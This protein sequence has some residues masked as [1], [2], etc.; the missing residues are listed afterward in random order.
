M[1]LRPPSICVPPASPD[2]G[3]T[4]GPG[5]CSRHQFWFPGSRPADL[6]R[7]RVRVRHRV[8]QGLVLVVGRGAGVVAR[9]APGFVASS[10]S[11]QLTV[12]R[13]RR[14][15]RGRCAP[16]RLRQPG[17]GAWPPGSGAMRLPKDLGLLRVCSPRT[18]T[19]RRSPA[20]APRGPARSGVA[21]RTRHRRNGQG[22]GARGEGSRGGG[23]AKQTPTKQTVQQ[24][25]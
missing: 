22:L 5:A 4:R 9:A 7:V 14:R 10:A 16:G 12:L 8:E 11:E 13:A 18:T 25:Q 2:P 20:G 3:P 19:E 17:R 21:Q 23:E 6:V 1:G 15:W 24:Q